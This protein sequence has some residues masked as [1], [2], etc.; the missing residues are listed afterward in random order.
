MGVRGRRTK[1]ASRFGI[2]RMGSGRKSPQ[3]AKPYAP[4]SAKHR[5]IPTVMRYGSGCHQPANCHI[6]SVMPYTSNTCHSHGRHSKC[7]TAN[8]PQSAA[9]RRKRRVSNE[10]VCYLHF[11]EE[12]HLPTLPP[13]PRREDSSRLPTLR[14]FTY[15]CCPNIHVRLSITFCIR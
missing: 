6:T 9:A 12:H 4:A 10:I 2:S 14:C 8:T 7:P 15:C 11:I 1:Q 13:P 5:A 3:Y